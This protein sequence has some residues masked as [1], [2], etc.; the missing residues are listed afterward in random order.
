[1]AKNGNFKKNVQKTWVFSLYCIIWDVFNGFWYEYYADKMCAVL[2]PIDWVINRFT[3]STKNGNFK[4][5]VQ[6]NWVFSLFCI[7]WKVF[8]E[9]FYEHYADKMCAMSRPIDWGLNRFIKIDKKWK[10]QEECAKNL[11]F[12]SLLHNLKSFPWVFLWTLCR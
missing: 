2:R 10:F 12:F 8:H 1:L 9:F 11:G 4:E 3:K 7:I 6:K 5:N